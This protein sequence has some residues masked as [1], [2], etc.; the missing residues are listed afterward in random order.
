MSACIV[1]PS[2]APHDQVYTL[3][4][5]L[6]EAMMQHTWKQGYLQ[7]VVHSCWLTAS[8]LAATL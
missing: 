5:A 6:E 1:P 4:R 2:H 7:A 8:S 3:L